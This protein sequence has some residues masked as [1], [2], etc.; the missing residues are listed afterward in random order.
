MVFSSPIAGSRNHFHA[1]PVTM[2]LSAMGYRKI[3]R[4]TPSPRIFW[5]RK[6]ASIR[7]MIVE[8]TM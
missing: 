4:N 8:M 5:S 1:V 3:G 6:I 2:K 7:P